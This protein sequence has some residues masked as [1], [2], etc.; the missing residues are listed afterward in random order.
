MNIKIQ[1]IKIYVQ[2]KQCLEE[3]MYKGKYIALNVLLKKR[4]E[5]KVIILISTLRN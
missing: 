1:H 4:K 3:E 2:Q 5:L